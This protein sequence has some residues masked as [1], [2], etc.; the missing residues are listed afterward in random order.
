MED[1]LDCLYAYLTE[2][3]LPRLPVPPELARR[4][5]QEAETQ[6][7]LLSALSRQQRRLYLQ[8]EDACNAC[9][10]AERRQLF[11]ETLRLARALER[12]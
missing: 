6:D 2:Q 8:Y 4:R 3:A 1:L 7:A 9:G 10:D 5:A 11:A 12:L